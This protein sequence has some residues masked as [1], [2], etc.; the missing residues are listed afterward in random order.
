MSPSGRSG[1]A[2]PAAHRPDSPWAVP[3][4]DRTPTR[5]QANPWPTGYRTGNPCDADETLPRAHPRLQMTATNLSR[6]ANCPCGIADAVFHLRR[7]QRGAGAHQAGDPPLEGHAGRQR[8]HEPRRLRSATGG[9]RP[10]GNHLLAD[11]VDYMGDSS[12]NMLDILEDEIRTATTHARSTAPNPGW[13]AI[14]YAI[15]I[16][17]TCDRYL[18]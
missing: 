3:L 5:Y 10:E 6:N 7:L 8:G 2:T 14:R 16:P 12:S 1:P 4:R 17:L 18:L 11:F 9:C 15:G 13:P